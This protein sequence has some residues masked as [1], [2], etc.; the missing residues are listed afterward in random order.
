MVHPTGTLDGM[1]VNTSPAL[2][3][4]ADTMQVSAAP[5]TA[6]AGPG[7]IQGVFVDPTGKQVG[8]QDLAGMK[9]MLTGSLDSMI[10]EIQSKSMTPEEKKRSI[11]AL[12]AAKKKLGKRLDRAHKSKQQ[13]SAA[14]ELTSVVDE[15]IA[16]IGLNGSD[17]DSFDMMRVVGQGFGSKSSAR[18]YF[19]EDTPFKNTAAALQQSMSTFQLPTTA[20]DGIDSIG[21][22]DPS[23]EMSELEAARMGN[24]SSTLA[25]TA[26]TPEAQAKRERSMKQFRDG[27]AVARE[28]AAAMREDPDNIS[29]SSLMD[30]FSGINTQVRGGEGDAGKLR[31]KRVAVGQLA[32][33]SAAALPE[34]AYRTFAM[35]AE[36]MKEIKANPDPKLAKT[37][38][39]HLAAFAY[40]MTI[41]E[42]MVSVPK[43]RVLVTVRVLVTSL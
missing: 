37:Q 7:V 1:P 2:E 24:S 41:S 14:D 3:H 33:P 39:V 20:A 32:P 29:F 27:A 30:L 15:A 5:E 10:L 23:D 13:F 28:G 40:Q 36:K 34:D 9:K 22:Y 31:G 42:Q 16:S 19:N 25:A 21:E 12:T 26:T 38:A 4:A 43:S 18:A 35:I 11:K 6:S 8:K 17:K